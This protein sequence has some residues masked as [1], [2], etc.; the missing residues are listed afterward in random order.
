MCR[1]ISVV[2]TTMI[3]AVPVVAMTMPIPVITRIRI[4]APAVT[5]P[6]VRADYDR[7]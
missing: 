5:V 3:I 6:V 7:G 4:I 1:W 2:V